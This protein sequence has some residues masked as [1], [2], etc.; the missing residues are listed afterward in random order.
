MLK[1]CFRINLAVRRL[2]GGFGGKI[3]RS[4]Q[5]AV[6]CSLVAFY[7]NRPCRFITPLT[8]FM[9]AIG[10][11]LPCSSDFEVSVNVNAPIPVII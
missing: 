3:S 11:R 4:T 1:L 6:A 5:I 9:R 7:L 10:K 2:G 8:T